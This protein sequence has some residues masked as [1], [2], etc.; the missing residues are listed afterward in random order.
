MEVIDEG[1]E[2]L[3]LRKFRGEANQRSA[4]TFAVSDGRIGRQFMVRQ[5]EIELYEDM[6]TE[7]ELGSHN[8]AWQVEQIV[9]SLSRKGLASCSSILEADAVTLTVFDSPRQVMRYPVA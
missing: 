3:V 6:A 4:K 2:A 9:A 8:G 7:L 5:T 1:L